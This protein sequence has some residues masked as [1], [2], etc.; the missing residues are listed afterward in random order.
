MSEKKQKTETLIK[1][2]KSIKSKNSEKMTFDFYKFINQEIEDEIIH[3]DLCLISKEPLEEN[4]LKLYCGHKFNYDSLYN[5]LKK[6]KNYKGYLITN[7]K[8]RLPKFAF[9]CPYCRKLFKRCVLPYRSGYLEILG[10][11]SPS[12]YSLLMNHCKFKMKNNLMCDKLCVDKLCSRHLKLYFKN[13]DN[14]TIEQFINENNEDKNKN[15]DKNENTSEQN[16]S[17]NENKMIERKC[18]AILKT[19]KRVGEKCLCK[20]DKSGYCKRHIKLKS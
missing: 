5:D 2:E 19:G 1:S 4:H 11:N 3:D 16:N 15:Q 18:N 20:C 13:Q 14:K 9:R 10:V 12:K 8:E 17:H 7:M 6:Q